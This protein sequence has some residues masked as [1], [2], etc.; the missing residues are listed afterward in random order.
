MS[1][2][3]FDPEKSRINYEKHGIDFNAAQH[4]FDDEAL[5]IIDGNSNFETRYIAI[6]RLD[7]KLWTAVYTWRSMKMRLISVRRARKSEIWAYEENLRRRI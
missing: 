7:G 4:I 2:F 1:Y 6:G 5:A 3:E